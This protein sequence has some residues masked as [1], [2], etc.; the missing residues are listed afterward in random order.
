MTRHSRTDSMPF[1]TRDSRFAELEAL[2]A[3]K[4]KPVTGATVALRTGRV[5]PGENAAGRW[6]L[7]RYFRWASRST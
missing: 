1:C 3:Q 7:L 4:A 6:S 5:V 2:A